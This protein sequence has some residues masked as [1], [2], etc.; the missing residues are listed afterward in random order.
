MK[1]CTGV[2]GYLLYLEAMEL[3][4][5]K[6]AGEDPIPWTEEKRDDIRKSLIN[7]I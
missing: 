2:E 7:S 6:L 5:Q 4:F 3:E 1:L